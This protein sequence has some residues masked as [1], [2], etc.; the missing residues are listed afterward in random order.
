MNSD[1]QVTRRYYIQKWCY[2]KMS[3]TDQHLEK[4]QTKQILIVRGQGLKQDYLDNQRLP[5]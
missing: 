2:V 4:R 5:L 3:F 1:S